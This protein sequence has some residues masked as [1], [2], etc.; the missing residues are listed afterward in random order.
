MW[1]KSSFCVQ[2][3]CAEV[4]TYR[5]AAAC[6]NGNSCAEVAFARPAACQQLE[7]AEIGVAG[8]HV[9]VRNSQ[10]PDAEVIFDADEWKAFV[11]G[12]QAGEFD[13]PA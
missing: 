10:R 13:L 11:L 1:R 5:R 2:G 8:D 12:I 6:A 9:H 7:C 3:E 4:L